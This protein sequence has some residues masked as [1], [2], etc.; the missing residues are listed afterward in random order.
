[1]KKTLVAVVACAFVLGAT[2]LLPAD[3]SPIGSAYAKGNGGG[4][5]NGGGNGGGHGGG[6]GSGHGGGNSGGKGG[7]QGGNHG[8]KSNGANL[9]GEHAG[10]A[11]RD[12][13]LSGNHYGSTRNDDNGHGAVTSGV[14]HSKDTRGLSKATA[15]SGTTPGDHNAK[16][17]GN[18]MDSSSKNDH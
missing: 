14:A 15:I 9:G 10:K 18:A 8:S 5:G 6:N 16:G 2:A 11:T 7:G 13:G 17:L 4:G 12:H 3:L 1:M